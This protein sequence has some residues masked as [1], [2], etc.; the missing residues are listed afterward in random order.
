MRNSSRY[1]IAG[2]CLMASLSVVGCGAPV[3]EESEPQVGTT[4]QSL[5]TAEPKR[6]ETERAL[7][8]PAEAAEWACHGFHNGARYCLANCEGIL[9]PVGTYPSIG[10]GECTNRAIEQCARFGR[11]FYGACWGIWR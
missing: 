4:H 6:V 11:A 8:L 5:S 9:I 10:W 3:T 7:P 2:I 1:L